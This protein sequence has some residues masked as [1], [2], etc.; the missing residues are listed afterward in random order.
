VAA[1][2]DAGA[3]AAAD[4]VAMSSPTDARTALT[5]VDRTLMGVPPDFIVEAGAG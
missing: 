1:D 3:A 2:A 4:A 5:R